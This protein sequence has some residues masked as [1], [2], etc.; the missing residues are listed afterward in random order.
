MACYILI[1]VY[2]VS[3]SVAITSRYF[4]DDLI[5]VC[6]YICMDESFTIRP[7]TF[8]KKIIILISCTL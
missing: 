8:N 5:C 2:A 6:I 3:V 4:V 1:F 7:V